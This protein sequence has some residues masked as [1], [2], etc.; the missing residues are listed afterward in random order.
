MDSVVTCLAFALVARFWNLTLVQDAN[1]AESPLVENGARIHVG[2]P[3]E[4][5]CELL[6]IWFPRFESLLSNWAFC[7]TCATSLGTKRYG[8][9]REIWSAVTSNAFLFPRSQGMW[10]GYFSR[11][12]RSSGDAEDLLGCNGRA[13]AHAST[14]AANGKVPEHTVL[15]FRIF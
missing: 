1:G 14:A 5:A 2:W 15:N 8:P 11:S 13:S 10:L 12:K 9:C 4:L 3:E 7:A 6:H